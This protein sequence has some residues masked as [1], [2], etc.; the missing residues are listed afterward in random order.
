[1]HNLIVTHKSERRLAMK[2]IHAY[3][4]T[5]GKFGKEFR[6]IVDTD[7]PFLYSGGYNR[8]K[9]RQEDL[10]EWYCPI[11]S[12]SIWYMN[13]FVRTEGVKYVYFKYVP[14]NHLFKDDHIYISYSRPITTKMNEYG[15]EDV[16]DFDVSICGNDI[17]PIIL[18]IEKYSPDC[19]TS[20]VRAKVQEKVEYYKTHYPKD[21]NR[22]FPNPNTDIFEYYREWLI[23]RNYLK[24]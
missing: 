15:F 21:Y 16:K 5:K 17:V 19:I 14:E 6:E 20:E 18:F 10:P 12:R 11:H 3:I 2:R 7:N 23:S 1:M 22:Q 13:G 4:Y 24:P 8:T 9:I